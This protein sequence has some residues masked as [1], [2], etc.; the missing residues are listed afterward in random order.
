MGIMDTFNKASRSMNEMSKNASETSNLRKKIAYENERI[1]EI[2]MEIGQLYYES[3]VQEVDKLKDLCADIDDRKRRIQSM[4]DEFY[5]IKGNRLCP[6]CGSSFDDK[7][8]FAFCGKCGAKL[9]DG[10]E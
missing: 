1:N 8:Q 10:A 3:E 4:K 9:E 6:T 7:Y 2:L 5:Q